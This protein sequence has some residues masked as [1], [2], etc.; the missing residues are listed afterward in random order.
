MEEELLLESCSGESYSAEDD[1]NT[2]P[3]NEDDS[4]ES[5]SFLVT[6]D[7]TDITVLRDT[8]TT[9]DA[10]MNTLFSYLSPIFQTSLSIPTVES[11]HFFD[12]LLTVF[13]T[14]I[15]PTYHSRHVQF[16]L[17]STSQFN[18]L[19]MDKFLCLLLERS[20]SPTLPIVARQASAAYLASFIARARS[21]PPVTIRTVTE[22][23]CLFL[24]RVLDEMPSGKFVPGGV[25]GN[26]GLEGVYAVFQAV[27][28]IYCFRWRE[29]SFMDEG[30]EQVWMS[31]LSVIQRMALSGLN[32]LAVHPPGEHG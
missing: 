26:M 8:I 14:R 1:I 29:L 4:T 30:G 24:S 25:A 2:E 3:T 17:F 23:L 31:Q 12:S 6:S 15:L 22:M 28:Y 5:S 20:L 9:L 19:F 18:P 13:L 10:L 7:T 32:P 21:L 11:E 16:I 27:V